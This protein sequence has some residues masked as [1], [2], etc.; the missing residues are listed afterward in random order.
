MTDEN[1]IVP[2]FHFRLNSLNL[3]QRF[4][5]ARTSVSFEVNLRPHRVQVRKRLVQ[6]CASLTRA[7]GTGHE[8][9]LP[10]Q[11]ADVVHIYPGKLRRRHKGG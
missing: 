1:G 7:G 9:G 10:N 5:C 4:G 8:V 6:R 3:W 11:H 2:V